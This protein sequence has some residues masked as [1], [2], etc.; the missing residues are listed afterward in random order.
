MTALTTVPFKY[1]PATCMSETAVRLMLRTHYMMHVYYAMTFVEVEE[2]NEDVKTLATNG[3]TC[4]INP[5]FW[6]QLTKEQRL[7]A[8]AHEMGH[9]MC[10]HSSRRGDRDPEIW[11]I[12]GDHVINLMLQESK[13][14]KLEGLTIDGK[15]WSWWCDAQYTGWTTEAVYDAL[16]K[17]FEDGDDGDEGGEGDEDEDGDGDGDG[18]PSPGAPRGKPRKSKRPPKMGAERDL[19]DYGTAPDGDKDAGTKGTKESFEQQVRKEMKEMAQ[20]AEMAGDAPNWIKRTMDNADH[21]RMPWYD[22]LEQYIKA[23]H[24]ADYSWRRWQRRHYVMTN[25]L[26][27]DMYEPAL[28]RV[29]IYVDASGSCWGA[30]PKF[31]KHINDIWTQ[32]NPAAVD[33]RYFQTEVN[34]E[35]DQTFERGEGDA[36]EVELVGGGGTDF[37]W[38]DRA[39]ADEPED[40][41][42]VLVLTDMY[43][44]GF[45]NEP[46]GV[47]V[48]WLSI[49][50][51]DQAPWGDVI[52]IQ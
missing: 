15:K 38:L 4:W 6:R 43:G 48:I 23:L 52:Q 39:I 13:F 22:V 1:K 16:V 19:V 28:G 50:S 11:N 24:K 29:L 35:Y 2:D 33:I 49:S 3:T 46:E 42:V 7:S 26:A 14:A 20:A 17:E 30:L 44:M 18:T 9:R 34:H 37:R 32:V 10:L 47:P 5:K 21:V 41:D 27:P 51:V 25:T 36:V 31:N 12:A 45:G 40:Y 8:V